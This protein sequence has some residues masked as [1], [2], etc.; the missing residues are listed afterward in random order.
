MDV[1]KKHLKVAYEKGKSSFYVNYGRLLN[2]Y[3]SGSDENGAF[4]RG[5]AQSNRRAPDATLR[6][7]EQRRLQEERRNEKRARSVELTPWEV[8]RA[9]LKMKG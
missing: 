4:E 1:D 6:E 2:P 8:K 5:W 9:Y 7:F 3:P